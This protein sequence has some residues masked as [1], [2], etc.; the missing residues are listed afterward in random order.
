MLKLICGPSGSGK[1]EKL[2]EMIGV[3]NMKVIEDDLK[4]KKAVDLMYDS[5][6]K[7]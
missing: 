3:D 5:A 4:V 1:T 2:T 7:K 6:V